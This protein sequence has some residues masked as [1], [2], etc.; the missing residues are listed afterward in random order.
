MAALGAL[1]TFTRITFPVFVLPLW[2]AL[3]VELWLARAHARYLRACVQA[4]VG[5]FSV[6]AIVCI[7]IDTWFYQR[8]RLPSEDWSAWLQVSLVVTPLNNLRYNWQRE[9]LAQHGLH[10]LFTHC[11]VN[12]FLLFGPLWAIAL[13]D[14]VCRLHICMRQLSKRVS[15]RSSSWKQRYFAML[16][17]S[18]WLPLAGL[19]MFPH[20]EPRF[21]LPLVVP[22]VSLYGDR[23]RRGTL[24]CWL[25]FNL[26]M[27]GIYGVSHQAGVINAAHYVY[28]HLHQTRN[29]PHHLHVILSHAYPLPR[30]LLAIAITAPA[31]SSRRCTVQNLGSTDAIAV[32]KLLT[33]L[34][35]KSVVSNCRSERALPV[36]VLAF[37][38]ANFR[39]VDVFAAL[40]FLPAGAMP[41]PHFSSEAPGTLLAHNFRMVLYYRIIHPVHLS[42]DVCLVPSIGLYPWLP[43]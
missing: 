21:L 36:A 4:A 27:F 23:I 33:N 18:I 31:M 8:H 29:Q 25:L 3:C 11:L 22:L 7:M 15:L 20:Q 26:V 2:L 19:S 41:W 24:A 9:N 28:G 5:S 14:F 42:L 13:H 39:Q 37:V 38:P 1:G 10:P 43:G 30:H 17:A 12:G 32:T 16:W 40:S 34:T 6:V 35:Q